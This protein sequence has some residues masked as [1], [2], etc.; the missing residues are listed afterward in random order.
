[1]RYFEALGEIRKAI[2]VFKK[3]SGPHEATIRE[4]RLSPG[5]MIVGEALRD[6]Q[7][8]LT[9]VPQFLGSASSIL[10]APDGQR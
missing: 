9:G 2:S 3:R 1:M 5:Q 6:F 8:V 7:G 4:F 10:K